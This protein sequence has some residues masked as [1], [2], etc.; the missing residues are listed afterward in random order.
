LKIEEISSKLRETKETLNLE[1]MKSELQRR[2]NSAENLRRTLSKLDHVLRNV[3]RSKEMNDEL[4]QIGF[5][6]RRIEDKINMLSQEI[7]K[8]S[9]LNDADQ[10][11]DTV[12]QVDREVSEVIKDIETARNRAMEELRKRLDEINRS[13]KIF[14]R[15]FNQLL[16]E[17]M[18]ISTFYS[19]SSSVLELNDKVREAETHL[20][21]VKEV[22]MEK[23]K[24]M[25]MDENS[26]TI[27]TK[28]MDEGKVRINRNN[29][30][31]AIK[32]IKLL[33]EKGIQ[34]EMSL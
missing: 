12:S 24:E 33:I 13:L 34:M 11:V 26:L 16:E 2:K 15:I 7:L 9:R 19:S 10:I 30:A 5:D 6:D 8:V 20:K 3:K 28:L 32:I 29:Y 25:K 14:A 23:I 1:Y 27:I 4:K 22:A 31:D 17:D 18:E 21:E